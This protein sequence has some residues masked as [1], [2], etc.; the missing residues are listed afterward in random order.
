MSAT[1]TLE[2]TLPSDGE[3]VIRANAFSAGETGAYTLRVETTRD[4]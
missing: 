2:V 1:K 3:Y 4:Q